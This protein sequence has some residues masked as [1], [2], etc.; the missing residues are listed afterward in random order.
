MRTII[1]TVTAALLVGC[2]DSHQLPAVQVSDGG[3]AFPE[4]AAPT[5]AEPECLEW[6][7]S[8]GSEYNEG[9]PEDIRCA[10]WS[11]EHDR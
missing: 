3:V 5:E 11:N 7:A 6:V 1:L 8:E 9:S 4:D 10:L 2:Y